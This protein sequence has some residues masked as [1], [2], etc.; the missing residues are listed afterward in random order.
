MPFRLICHM[1][2]FR[3]RPGIPAGNRTSSGWSRFRPD[4]KISVPVHPYCDVIDSPVVCSDII[5]TQMSHKSMDFH[6]YYLPVTGYRIDVEM[7]W[8]GFC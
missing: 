5:S 2:K 4:P 3:F 8:M 1:E 7:M 6:L